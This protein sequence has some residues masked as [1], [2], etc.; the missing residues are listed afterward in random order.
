MH[1]SDGAQFKF[2]EMHRLSGKV[3]LNKSNSN[4][5]YCAQNPWL[6]H[7]T[8]RDNI[9]FR[10][11]FDPVRY[12]AVLVAC[13]LKRD[14]EIFDAGD[15]TEIGEKVR[16]FHASSFRTYLFKSWLCRV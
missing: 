13:G 15:M 11:P 12:D 1:I 14:L 5:A 6:E 10:T 8:I 3:N 16:N 4:V 9:L 7:A 2:S